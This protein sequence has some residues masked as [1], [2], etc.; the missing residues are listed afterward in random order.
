M[1]DD[2]CVLPLSACQ[3]GYYEYLH[4]VQAVAPQRFA[5]LFV[6]GFTIIFVCGTLSVDQQI[7]PHD[8]PIFFRIIYF[9]DLE[10][11]RKSADQN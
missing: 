7:E 4:F 8:V 1:K 11:N 6:L 3:C 9:C 5:F 2:S 10:T